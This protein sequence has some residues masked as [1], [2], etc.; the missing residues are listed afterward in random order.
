MSDRHTL[1][2]TV[3][4][5]QAS[6]DHIGERGPLDLML[7]ELFADVAKRTARR[8]VLLRLD[9]PVDGEIAVEIQARRPC[10]LVAAAWRCLG[11]HVG[12]WEERG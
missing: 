11:Q 2:I 10:W 8:T 6:L 5:L 1:A 12:L 7:I 4:E 3:K 9:F